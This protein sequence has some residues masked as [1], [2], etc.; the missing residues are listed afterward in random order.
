MILAET[1]VASDG[2]MIYVVGGWTEAGGGSP[3]VVAYD[4]MNDTWAQLPGYPL[5]IHHAQA[6]AID[7]TLYVFGG[8]MTTVP[9]PGSVVG[10]GPFGWPRTP[11][12]FRLAPGASAWEPIAQMPEARA[13]GGAAVV[14]GLVY[15]V[16]GIG[17]DGYLSVVH[18]YDPAQDR[19]QEAA[20]L[21]TTR[22]HLSVLA[23][24]GR[25]YALAGRSNEGGAWD[26]LETL[27]VLDVPNGSW[28]RL[29]DA[30]LGRGGQGAGVIAGG[31]LALVGGERAEGEFAVYDDAHAYDVATDA[32]IE[33]PRLPEPLHGM[34][35]A[36]WEGTLILFGGATEQEIR[37]GA[38]A[39]A[40]QEG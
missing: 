26:D 8:A 30:P 11:L 13:L 33:L 27:E 22:D 40:P 28:T 21:P 7:G 23:Q 1:A 35:A 3:F 32:W 2:P 38:W 12:A 29:A 20:P 4:A 6:A 18:V 5:A 15:L 31:Q 16:G 37:T 25:V 39:L 36:S 17:L 34:P 24:E 9:L 14:D 19:Y 10:V